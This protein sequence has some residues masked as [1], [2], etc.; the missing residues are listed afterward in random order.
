MCGFTIN[1]VQFPGSATKL[2]C[3]KQAAPFQKLMHQDSESLRQDRN[4]NDV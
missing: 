2:L 1:Y 3:M 4:D